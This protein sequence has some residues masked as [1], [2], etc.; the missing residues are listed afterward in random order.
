[1]V[2]RWLYNKFISLSPIG[3]TITIAIVS[4]VVYILIM[5]RQ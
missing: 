5:T 4:L 1:M 3:K 2:T